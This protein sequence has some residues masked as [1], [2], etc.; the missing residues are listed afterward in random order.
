MNKTL[1]DF[2]PPPEVLIE[3][4]PEEVA[5]RLLMY[6]NY[7]VKQDNNRNK[8]HISSH[9]NESNPVFVGYSGVYR[10]QVLFVLA[11]AWGWL[12]QQNFLC[13]DPTEPLSNGWLFISRRGKTIQSTDDF[14]KYAHIS[15]L[16]RNVLDP[17]LNKKVWPSF[18][19]GD[20]DTAIF[21]AFKEVEVRM[22]TTAGL[23]TS[24]IGWR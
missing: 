17:A 6:L 18:I 10:D 8:V 23:D 9:L 22:R 7:F 3:L 4:E 1:K 13:P 16:P 5:P 21:A 15:L 19:D 12:V 14:K 20:F 24:H 2:L 11:E